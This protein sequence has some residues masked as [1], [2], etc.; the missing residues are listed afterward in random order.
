[1]DPRK[2]NTIPFFPVFWVENWLMPVQYHK[3]INAI[4]RFA[5][6]QHALE[7]NDV[8]KNTSKWTNQANNHSFNWKPSNQ[9]INQSNTYPPRETTPIQQIY[10]SINQSI[11]GTLMSKHIGHFTTHIPHMQAPFQRRPQTVGTG[12]HHFLLNLLDSAFEFLVFYK[13]GKKTPHWSQYGCGRKSQQQNKNSSSGIW[14]TATTKKYEPTD[15][16]N[17]LTVKTRWDFQTPRNENRHRINPLQ[18]NR[19]N[20]PEA[21]EWSSKWFR[22]RGGAP[23][24]LT[25]SSLSSTWLSSQ[26]GQLTLNSLINHFSEW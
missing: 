15:F 9:S 24:W 21:Q 3:N 10:Q 8:E 22:D 6:H 25:S 26:T 23:T 4:W 13:G 7:S 5:P 1:M 14:Q 12:A 16:L 11:A 2:C 20:E 19:K 18:H 17:L